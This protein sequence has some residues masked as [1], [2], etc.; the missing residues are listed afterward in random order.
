MI[1]TNKQHHLCPLGAGLA[2]HGD[3]LYTAQDKVCPRGSF[4]S[5]LHKSSKGAK[6]ETEEVDFEGS[7]WCGQAERREGYTDLP[8]LEGKQ[9]SPELEES[10]LPLP[11]RQ[12]GPKAGRLPPSQGGKEC[13][14]VPLVKSGGWDFLSQSGANPAF[15]AESPPQETTRIRSKVKATLGTA[16]ATQPARETGGGPGG[17]RGS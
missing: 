13:E 8:A 12:P 7:P 5:E 17:A 1:T 2:K 11:L 4:R 9:E 10:Y 15:A 3:G 6:M 14:T 16:P